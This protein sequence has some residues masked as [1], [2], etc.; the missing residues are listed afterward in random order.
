MISGPFAL[1]Q[2]G[3]AGPKFNKRKYSHISIISNLLPN[4]SELNPFRNHNCASLLR[5]AR[6]LW[7]LRIGAVDLE[8][9]ALT[10]SVVHN[11]KF[12]SPSVVLGRKTSIA[13]VNIDDD[14]VLR[15]TTYKDFTS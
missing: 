12:V 7:K 1:K 14:V 9:D 15:Y 5:K 4:P 11:A 10:R 8:V 2:G 13:E 6:T 3:T